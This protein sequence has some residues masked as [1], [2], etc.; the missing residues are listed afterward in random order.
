VTVVP[1][2]DDGVVDLDKVIGEAEAEAARRRA[3]PGYPHDRVAEIEAALARFAPAT[4]G[5][6]RLEHLVTAIE[7]ASYV[8]VDAPTASARRGVSPVKEGMKRVLGWY[9]RHLADQVSTLGLLTARALSAFTERLDELERRIDHQAEPGA[10]AISALSPTA[11]G[12]EKLVA[13]WAGTVEDL[14]AGV[15]GRVLYADADAEAMVARLRG[16]GLDAYG[17][18]PSGDPYL[19]STDT[20]QADLLAH[21]DSIDAGALGGVVLAGYPDVVDGVSFQPVIDRLARVVGPGGRVTIVS[22]A[23]WWWRERLGPVDA[24]LARV[25]PL[26]AETWVATFD[27]A[28][29]TTTARYAADGRSY[30]VVAQRVA[31]P[32]EPK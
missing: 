3:A 18:T 21:L 9:G 28:G 23:P 17:V 29:F 22:E 13:A 10:V 6:Q 14:M 1:A 11:P 24:D 26:A 16:A 2:P 5:R 15:G 19:V 4:R 25:R 8:D 27:R 31:Q 30:G 32:G 7:E 20:R 12:P